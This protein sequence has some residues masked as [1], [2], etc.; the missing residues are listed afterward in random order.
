MTRYSA[1]SLPEIAAAFAGF[2][3]DLE[4]RAAH[5]PQPREREIL[6]A[7]AGAWR[8]ASRVLSAATLAASPAP[9]ARKVL[10]PADLCPAV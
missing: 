6:R 7:R 10:W 1:T 3:E 2:A 5:A 8:E 9:A 4:Q